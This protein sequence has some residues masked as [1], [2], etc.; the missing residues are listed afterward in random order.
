MPASVR[1]SIA[2]GPDVSLV[3]SF[4]PEIIYIDAS[5]R[6]AVLTR[7][8]LSQFPKSKIINVHDSKYLIEKTKKEFNDIKERSSLLDKSKTQILLS[9]QKGTFIKKCPGS[10]N[11]ICCNYFVINQ[12][13]NC[14]F[15]CSYCFLQRYLNSP[16][17]TI[18][19]NPT[20]TQNHPNLP[21]P[22]DQ[23][24]R[25]PHH[26]HHLHPQASQARILPSQRGSRREPH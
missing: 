25:P 26:H 14:N 1:I 6:D 11:V 5:S 10:K 3:M 22:A 19:T 24:L 21:V 9:T 8:I 13:V 15:D 4:S 20:F 12:T 23:D 17:I 7:R 2:V 18:Y 16:F